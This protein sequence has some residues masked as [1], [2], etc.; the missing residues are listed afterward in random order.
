MIVA[1]GESP[2]EPESLKG[3]AFFGDSAEQAERLAIMYLGEG[4]PGN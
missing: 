4:V 3:I 1:D 2:P